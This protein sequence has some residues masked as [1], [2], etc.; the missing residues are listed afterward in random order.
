MRITTCWGWDP[1]YPDEGPTLVASYDEH[2]ADCWNGIPDFYTEEVAKYRADVEDRIQ[3]REMN[4]EV[5]GYAVWGLFDV[6]EINGTPIE[7]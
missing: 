4:I 7:D 3:I 2:T 5:S 1:K 6:P